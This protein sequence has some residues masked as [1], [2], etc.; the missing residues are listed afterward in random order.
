M[1]RIN[2][3][4]VLYSFTKPKTTLYNRIFSPS[5]SYPNSYHHLA[6]LKQICRFLSFCKPKLSQIQI[7]SNFDAC[8]TQSE[9]GNLG[10]EI[11]YTIFLAISLF[12]NVFYITYNFAISMPEYGADLHIHIDGPC[13]TASI[14][15]MAQGIWASGLDVVAVLEHDRITSEH[16]FAVQQELERLSENDRR[17]IFLYLAVESTL[18]FD[19]LPYHISYIY[20]NQFGEQNLPDVPEPYSD[21]RI[22]EEYKR[23]YPGVANLDHPAFKDWPMD[24]YG[25]ESTLAL[26]KSGLVD[27]ITVANG[28]ILHDGIGILGSGPC[29][30]EQGFK[31]F[32][33]GQQDGV[34]MANIGSSDAHMGYLVGSAFTRFTA[35][36]PCGIFHAIKERQT[37]A[38]VKNIGES[39]RNLMKLQKVIPGVTDYIEMAF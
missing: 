21:V 26:M 34:Q 38:I 35:D 2:N 27:G 12:F 19:R 15:K 24:Q 1:R 39:R 13:H 23:T 30:L 20:K 5:F 25:T 11:G 32:L 29:T 37:I 3:Q 9:F 8:P 6:K 4:L 28:T 16:Y 14:N 10:L 33:R 17:R 22:L 18:M 31:V 7:K 36:S